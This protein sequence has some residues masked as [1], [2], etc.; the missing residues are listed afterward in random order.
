MAESTGLTVEQTMETK[1]NRARTFGVTETFM[2]LLG[3]SFSDTLE[4]R[5][6]DMTNPTKNL[7]D[8]MSTAK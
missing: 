1:T 8:Y 2:G 3:Y 5:S 4:T 6:P 7:K